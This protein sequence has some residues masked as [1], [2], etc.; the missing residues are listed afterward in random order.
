MGGLSYALSLELDIRYLDLVHSSDS[1]LNVETSR[2]VPETQWA[3]AE[4]V[5]KE[6]A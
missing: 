3:D 2:L 1:K 5:I 4:E 6:K